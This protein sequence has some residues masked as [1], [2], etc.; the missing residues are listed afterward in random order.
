MRGF[1]S[2]EYVSAPVRVGLV[3]DPTPSPRPSSFFLLSSFF[4][5]HQDFLRNWRFAEVK[6]HFGSNRAPPPFGLPQ[7]EIFLIQTWD[8]G[9]RGRQKMGPS[10]LGLKK[11][12][13]W[14]G[15]P[16]NPPQPLTPIRNCGGLCRISM[17]FLLAVTRSRAVGGRSTRCA[18]ARIS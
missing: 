15:G 9:R 10:I 17:D 11:G 8:R 14:H 2:R 4:F 3:G 18:P 16:F 12:Q 5:S 7:H 13:K 6:S 1:R